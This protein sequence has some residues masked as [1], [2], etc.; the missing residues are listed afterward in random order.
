[1]MACRY[2]FL[3]EEITFQ[4]SITCL[5]YPIYPIPLYSPKN[6]IPQETAHIPDFFIL[7]ILQMCLLQCLLI[8]S[9]NSSKEFP[10]QSFLNVHHPEQSPFPV[11]ISLNFTILP[12]PLP[13]EKFSHS[14][15]SY[16]FNQTISFIYYSNSHI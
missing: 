6:D 15:N 4:H 10:L 1:M 11:P 9:N 12:P 2:N 3:L 7:P 8:H 14:L 5:S 16:L 13:S